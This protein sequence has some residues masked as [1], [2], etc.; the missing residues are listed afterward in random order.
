METRYVPADGG[1]WF[2]SFEGNTAYTYYRG[3]LEE[4]GYWDAH[5]FPDDDP[6]YQ[7]WRE[8]YLLD[9]FGRRAATLH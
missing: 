2:V 5:Y 3:Q 6:Y 9:I 4:I 1:G 8:K 7:N